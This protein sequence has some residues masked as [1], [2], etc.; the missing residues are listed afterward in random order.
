MFHSADFLF[1]LILAI[2]LLFRLKSILGS[3]KDENSKQNK[4]ERKSHLYENVSNITKETV[5]ESSLNE[6]A[7]EGN[8]EDN[9][10]ENKIELPQDGSVILKG[11]V[12]KQVTAIENKLPNFD[13]KEFLSKVGVAFEYIAV[14]F[15]KNDKE[16]LK[17]LLGRNIYTKFCKI[18][19]SRIEN[20]EVAEFS[21][22]GFKNVEILKVVNVGR[23]VDI[24]VK[25]L[26]EQTNIVKNEK[27]EIICGD[28]TYIETVTDVW[29]FRKDTKDTNPTWTLVATH[30]YED[31]K[32]EE[33][34]AEEV[35]ENAEEQE[36][37][38]EK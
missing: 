16:A 4:E 34:S 25:F 38:E 31:E 17:K 8:S 3:N 18:I 27:G 9:K 30:P 28:P 36:K 2:L 37:V 19:D 10:K 32:E 26:T 21:L 13:M 14:S 29:T 6:E 1:L 33:N 24:S 15:A 5:K 20:K 35:V 11:N 22:I 12:L 23:V 7:K